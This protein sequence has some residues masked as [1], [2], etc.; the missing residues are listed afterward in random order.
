MA[1]DPRKEN[2]KGWSTL[3]LISD[4]LS[5]DFETFA[6]VSQEL[7]RGSRA[8]LSLNEKSWSHYL[9]MHPSMRRLKM[10]LCS[11]HPFLALHFHVQHVQ[12]PE[13]FQKL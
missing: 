9:M 12:T 2:G 4:Y 6:L 5:Q 7:R 1:E 11:L 8:V 10:S 3:N 13:I